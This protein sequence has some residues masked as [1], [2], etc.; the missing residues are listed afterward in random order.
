MTKLVSGQIAPVSGSYN[1]I[2][3]NGTF[4]GVVYVKRGKRMPPTETPDAHFEI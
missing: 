4:L 3:E 2:G 1:V